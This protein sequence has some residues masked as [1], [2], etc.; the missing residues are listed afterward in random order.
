[1][2]VWPIICTAYTV[3]AL[4]SYG[5]QRAYIGTTYVDMTQYSYGHI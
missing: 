5:P 2:Y 1:M 4:Y 3:T